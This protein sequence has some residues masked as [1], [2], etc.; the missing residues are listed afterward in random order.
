MK[1]LY[2]TMESKGRSLKWDEGKEFKFTDY[3]KTAEQLFSRRKK[4]N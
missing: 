4:K 2:E 1:K 3:V